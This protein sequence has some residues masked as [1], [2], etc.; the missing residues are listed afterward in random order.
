MKKRLGEKVKIIKAVEI[1]K[2]DLLTMGGTEED[3]AK[4]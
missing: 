4:Q 2:D 3:V 1:K